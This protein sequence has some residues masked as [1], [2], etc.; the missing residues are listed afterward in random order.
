MEY[1]I[2]ASSDGRFV[3]LSQEPSFATEESGEYKVQSAECRV[4]GC[5]PDP[6][7]REKR[8]N[9]EKKAKGVM[10]RRRRMEE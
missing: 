1:K 3:E 6:N 5:A 4:R 7:R 9:R 8:A 2:S 10:R